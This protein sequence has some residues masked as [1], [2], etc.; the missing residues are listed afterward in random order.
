[1]AK[2]TSWIRSGLHTVTPRLILKDA[3]KAVAFY[4]KALGA[5]RR[6]I[7]MTPD[8]AKVMHGEIQIGDSVIFVV[9]EV[10]HM[11]VLSPESSGAPGSSLS[12]AVEDADKL[13]N[14]A[15]AAGCTVK[16]PL[17]D[18]F[19]GDRYGAVTDPFGNTWDICTHIEDLTQAEIE[20]RAKAAFAV[21]GAS[22]K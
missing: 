15:I 12:I 16:M 1:M 3:Q 2:A 8:G 14:Q 4:E 10:P 19:W 17:N 7:S 20:T 21:Q 5:Q 11:G 9:D 18:M 13:F 22:C 6:M